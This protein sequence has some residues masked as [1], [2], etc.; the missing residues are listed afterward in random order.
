MATR[1]KITEIMWNIYRD[2]Y[3]NSEPHGNFDM[4]VENAPILDDGRK[5]I[6]YNDYEI[7][8]D[9][10]NEIINQHL[11]SHRLSKIDKQTIRAGILLGCSPKTKIK[12][13]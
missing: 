3:A 1:K 4:L 5:Y 11:S 8:E 10:M 7:E 6:P 9:V 13:E 12:H 2:L